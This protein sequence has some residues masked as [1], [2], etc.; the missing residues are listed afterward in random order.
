M[1]LYADNRRLAEQL[2]ETAFA[3]MRN[4][5]AEPGDCLALAY[6]LL[7]DGIDVSPAQRAALREFLVQALTRPAVTAAE[8]LAGGN[9]Q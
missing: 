6:R 5:G 7:A 9:P 3:L 8:T 1:K 2:L 4:E